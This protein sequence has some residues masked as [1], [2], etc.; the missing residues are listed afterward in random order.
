MS[1]ERHF[2]IVKSG[3][4]S[5]EGVQTLAGEEGLGRSGCVGA[6]REQGRGLLG[7]SRPAHVLPWYLNRD[8]GNVSP[9]FDRLLKPTEEQTH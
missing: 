8:S 2:F 6:G 5:S 7:G 9:L 1:R 3:L 4:V